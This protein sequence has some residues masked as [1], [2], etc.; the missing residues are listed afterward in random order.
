ML[1]VHFLN[2]GQG[3]CTVIQHPS[4][5]LTVVDVNN[6][7]RLDPQSLR[8]IQMYG[9]P[10][11]QRFCRE[12][13]LPSN[14]TIRLENPIAFLKAY[15]P[16]KSIHRYIQSHP[17]LDH[18]RGLSA[19]V[20]SRIGIVNMWD[21]E[22]QKVPEFQ[23][24]GDLAD[25][26]AYMQMRSGGNGV[27]VLQLYR[28]WSAAFWNKGEEPLD[29][30]DGIQ[31]LSPTPE[32]AWAAAESNSWNN[33]SYVLKV[34]YAGLDIVLSGDAEKEAWD[35]IV[36]HYGSSLKCHV[37]KASHHGR[38]SGYHQEAVKLMSPEYTI[39]S[40]GKKPSSDASNKYRQ[41]T[42]KGV[43][44]TRWKGNITVAV[45]SDGRASIGAEADIPSYATA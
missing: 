16:N 39:V 18:R 31:I 24:D 6:G 21:T 14:Y 19:F 7:E 9:S 15:Y 23:S 2:V 41:Y 37:L 17:D 20:S 33:L 10:V 43:W 44:S 40:V 35:S 26:G 34:S 12:Y 5:R 27:K 36:G 42:S 22:H 38:D 32:L 30:G 45:N 8:E 29:L 25:W 13:W 28:G 11:L 4:G 1:K 3:D